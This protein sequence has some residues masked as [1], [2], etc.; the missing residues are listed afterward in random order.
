MTKSAA[1]SKHVVSLRHKVNTSAALT[2]SLTETTPDTSLKR[3]KLTNKLQRILVVDDSPICRKVL[4]K[5]LEQHGFATDFAC[6]GQEACDKLNV[7]PCAFDAVLMDLRMP[8]M[9]GLTA[10]R[11]CKERSHLASVPFI[12]VTAELGEDIRQAAMDAGASNFISKPA[13][14]SELLAIL[15]D[16]I[17]DV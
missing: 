3:K 12:V 13:R 2:E 4:I 11:L 15:N 5:S 7:V 17:K 6:D 14:I 8:I 1:G 9:D 10:T 16:E